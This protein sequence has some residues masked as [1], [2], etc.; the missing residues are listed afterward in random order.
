MGN[1]A[2][3][4]GSG[5]RLIAMPA[6]HLIHETSPY[7]LQHADNPV[8]WFPWG[9]QALR[10]AREQNKPILL[11]IGYSACHWCHVMAHESFEDA[12][13]AALMNE[14]FINIKVDREERPDLDHIY[15]AAQSMLTG[16][17][18]GWPL[19]MFLTPQQQPFFGGTYFPKQARY[20]LPGFADLL[21]R[22]AA[23]FREHADDI[24]RQGAE[25]AKAFVHNQPI[26]SDSEIDALPLAAA[27]RDLE[28]T[29]DPQYGGFGGAPKF[30]HPAELELC[31]REAA[32]CGD[33][34]L[35]QMSLHSLRHMALG[36]LYDQ[37]GGGFF[38]YSVDERWEIPHFEKMLYD[39]AQ[40]LPL[41]VDAWLLTRDPLYR[42]IAEET[43]KWVMREM[44]SPD[45]GY[46]ST[47][48]A[49]SEHEEG[50][51]Y[52]WTREEIRDALSAPEYEVCVS[53]YGLDRPPNFEGRWHLRVARSLEE[54]AQHHELTPE[55]GETLLS[56]IRTKLLGVRERRVRPGRDEKIITSWNGL[57]IKGMAHAARAFDR[58]DWLHSARIAADF[59]QAK[60]WRNSRLLAVFKDGQARFNAYLDDYAF[61]LEALLELLQAEFQVSDL[62]FARSIAKVML[63]QFHDK[64]RGDFFFTALDHE[65]LLHRPK[66]LHD[67]ATPNGIA[68]AARALQRLGCMVGEP[69]YTDAAQQVLNLYYRTMRDYPG[70]FAT[71][72]MVLQ[73]YV[74][75]LR[76]LVLRDSKGD[77]SPWFAVLRESCNYG[78]LCVAPAAE[79][80]DLPPTLDKPDLQEAAAWL[81]QGSKC[82]P[83]VLDP[84]ELRIL[85]R[86]NVNL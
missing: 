60:M 82:L 35:A 13:V 65:K 66:P 71:L 55:A 32:R 29:F 75:P 51:F 23:F 36:G 19:T 31:L 59:I 52:A 20:N 3:L 15:Q 37:L 58:A 46:F 78:L 63:T 76:L 74:S 11:S 26:A 30:P 12:E 68:V 64:D 33:E 67:N 69:H 21:P 45:G 7:L 50:K 6:N 4:A 43:A 34:S 61:L 86:N 25:L 79:L 77:L 62:V 54:V 70:G 44:Q 73:E 48:D 9:E 5:Q 17:H 24:E 83:A 39:N 8:D 27:M 28:A 40:L 57:M 22:V 16:S 10:L 84:D 38:R 47:L 41:Y 53:Y 14:H 18:G 42:R 81:C 49:D 85:L 2:G 80:P 56:I 1:A 72:L